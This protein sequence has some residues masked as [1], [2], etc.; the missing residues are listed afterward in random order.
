MPFTRC[1]RA[2]SCLYYSMQRLVSR[3]LSAIAVAFAVP[4]HR[5]ALCSPYL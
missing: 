3:S 2:N 4:L 5:D 1:E